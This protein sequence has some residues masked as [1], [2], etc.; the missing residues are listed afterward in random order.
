MLKIGEGLYVKKSTLPEAGLGLFVSSPIRKNQMFTRYEG[1]LIDNKEALQLRQQNKASHIKTLAHGFNHIDGIQVPLIGCGGGSFANDG[2]NK[3]I[4]NATYIRIF[5][6][7]E[8]KDEIY[9][10]ALRDIQIDE[11]VFVSYGKN[12]WILRDN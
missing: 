1:K 9:L 5:N 4:N 12:Y 7:K 8:A 10:K 2:R 11:E 6:K 3:K